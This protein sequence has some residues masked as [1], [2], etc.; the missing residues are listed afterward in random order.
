MIRLKTR[1]VWKIRGEKVGKEGSKRESCRKVRR[2]NEKRMQSAR[3]ANKLDIGGNG[4]VEG[5][6]DCSKQGGHLIL[7]WAGGGQEERGQIDGPNCS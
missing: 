4:D 3:K 6:V 5:G 1:V 7:G 2:V